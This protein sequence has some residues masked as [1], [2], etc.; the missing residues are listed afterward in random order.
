MLAARHDDDDDDEGS[1]PSLLPYNFNL[2]PSIT[3]GNGGVKICI[4]S[5]FSPVG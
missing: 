1:C 3:S 4:N 2:G 5:C